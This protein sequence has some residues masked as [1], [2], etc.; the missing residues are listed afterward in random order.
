MS[1]GRVENLDPCMDTETAKARGKQ[2]GIASGIARREKKLMS[3]I[4]AD[5]L[6]KK[7]EVTLKDSE[8]NII[9]NKKIPASQ[10]IERTVSAI[11]AR[12]DSASAT[13]IKTIGELTE[14]NKLRIGGLNSDVIP[15]EY[16]DPPNASTE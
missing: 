11:L 15:F 3:Q 13:M 4:L 6:Q 9:D 10:L 5:Y 2:G 1:N 16:V 14:G 7:H 8:G 12:G